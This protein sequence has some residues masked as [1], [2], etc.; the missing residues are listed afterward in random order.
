MVFFS[1]TT[2]RLWEKGETSGNYL[3]LVDMRLD[4]DADTLLVTALPDRAGVPHR[5]APP[6]SAMS[7]SPPPRR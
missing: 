7:R 2:Q 6:A 1:R 5:H 3:Q 4:C